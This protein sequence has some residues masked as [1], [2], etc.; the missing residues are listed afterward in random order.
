M[1]WSESDKARSS[2]PRLFDGRWTCRDLICLAER[3]L[4]EHDKA[5]FA[6]FNAHRVR[7]LR[8][9]IHPTEAQSHGAARPMTPVRLNRLLFHAGLVR[10]SRWP[11]FWHVL[12]WNLTTAPGAEQQRSA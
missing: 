11:T 5:T 1:P 7:Q 3:Y 4:V 2:K 8:N 9:E 6:L 12:S 10:S